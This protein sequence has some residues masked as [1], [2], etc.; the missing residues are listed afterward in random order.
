MGRFDRHWGGGGWGGGWGGGPFMRRRGFPLFGGG[1]FG[2]GMGM[3]G[4]G[5]MGDLLAGGLGYMVGRQQGTQNQQ[6]TPQYQP[7]VQ[8]YQPQYQP[9]VQQYQPSVQ[10]YQQGTPQYRPQ[11]PQGNA[12]S[13]QIAQLRLLGDLHDKGVLTNDEFQQ[14]KQKILNGF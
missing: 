10:Q 13:G 2:M 1:G 9:P 4:G 5:L 3:G 7:P 11:A 8:Q 12:Q 14:E 6:Y